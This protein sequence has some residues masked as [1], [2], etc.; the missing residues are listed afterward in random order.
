MTSYKEIG[1][2]Y[3]LEGAAGLEPVVDIEAG[4]QH[5]ETRPGALEAAAAALR[6]SG[7]SY[8]G[9]EPTPVRP[10]VASSNWPNFPA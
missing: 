5:P 7:V 8:A 3:R 2:D 9:E 6:G 1:K 4:S 10:A